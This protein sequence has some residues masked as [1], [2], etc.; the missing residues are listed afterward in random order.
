[1][2]YAQM[3]QFD[4]ANGVG[5]RSTLFVSGCSFH[6]P[7]CFNEEYQDFQ[8]GIPWTKESEDQFISYL[9]HPRNDGASIL[10]GEPFQQDII[11]LDSLLQRIKKETG[12]SIWVWTGYRF[13]D[14]LNT[15]I[16]LVLEYIDVIVDG[17]FIE[18]LR[19]MR[20]QFRG[21]SNQRIID[22]Q[23][24]L[25]SEEVVLWNRESSE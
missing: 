5:I 21:S 18:S 9:Q 23:K 22:V 14:L 11:V 7:G 8:Y 6:C 3:R 25:E 20:L 4:V 10:G 2:N 19:D 16:R 15:R 24:S 1:M 12:K 13:E 17:Q